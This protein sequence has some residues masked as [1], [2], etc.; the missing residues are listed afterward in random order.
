M[1]SLALT[2][3]PRAATRRKAA[4]AVRAQGRIPANIYGKTA[5][6]QNVEVDA[7]EF[8]LLVGRAHSEIILVDLTVQGDARPSRLAAPR[9]MPTTPMRCAHRARRSDRSWSNTATASN[10]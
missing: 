9:C 2:V 8:G 3:Y 5:A 1:N 4:K 10:P 7:K 6:A